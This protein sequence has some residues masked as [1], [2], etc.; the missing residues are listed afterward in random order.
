MGKTEDLFQFEL[1]MKTIFLIT[2]FIYLMFF[3]FL[4]MSAAGMAAEVDG[5]VD[6]LALAALLIKNQNYSRAASVLAEIKDP[7]EVIPE[8]Y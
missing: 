6:Q 1:I 7:H 4:A 8:R 5:E 2:M 3:S